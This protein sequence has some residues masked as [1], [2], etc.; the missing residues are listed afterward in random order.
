MNFIIWLV[1]GGLIGWIASMIMRTDGQQGIFLNI[2]VGIVGAFLG[3]WLISPL[4]GVPTI[5]QNA[6]SVGALVVSLLGAV[7]LL[8]IVNLF[9]RG[10]VR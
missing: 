7:I 2:I 9:R 5:N 4:V 1:V 8:A 10:A 3:G 6:F